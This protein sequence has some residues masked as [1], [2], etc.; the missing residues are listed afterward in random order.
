METRTE[1]LTELVERARHEAVLAGEIG[2]WRGSI[3]WDLPE[4]IRDAIAADLASGVYERVVSDAMG[5]DPEMV[6]Q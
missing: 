6:Q 5:P 1:E 2:P 3:S 4:S